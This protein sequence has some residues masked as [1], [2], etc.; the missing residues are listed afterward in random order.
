MPSPRASGSAAV[1]IGATEPSYDAAATDGYWSLPFKSSDLDRE[2][3]VATDPLLG[4]GRAAVGGY[5]QR[6]TVEGT[7]V[8]PIDVRAVGFWLHGLMGAP[9]T[10]GAASAGEITFSAQPVAE[11][12]ITLNG[13]AWTFKT[14]GAT[15][16]QTNIGVSLAATLT[17]LAADLNASAS[18]EIAKNT[19]TATATQLRIVS[20]TP[21][22][23]GNTYTLAASATSKGTVSAGT[24]KGGGFSHV[25]TAGADIPSKSLQVGH[26]GLTTPK[27][28]LYTGCFLGTFNTSVA[29]DAPANASVQ[30]IGR[31]KELRT[32]T[33]DATVVSHQVDRFS[34]SRAGITY[35]GSNGINFLT[36]AEFNY[37]NNLE[38]FNEIAPTDVIGG[39]D[40]G[41]AQPSGSLTVRL[42]DSAAQ[43]DL[44]SRIET[45]DPV[46]LT[47]TYGHG[48]RWS[49]VFDMPRVL[50]S[51]AKAPITGPG[52]IEQTFQWLAE[53]DSAEGYGLRATLI[54]DVAAYL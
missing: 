6:Q 26:S 53:H 17:A 31:R 48:N 28:S 14:S 21:G 16:T 15:G 3:A 13:V 2:R 5:Y 25:F 22:V 47:Y 36:G 43:A 27:Y 40:P 1:L 46:S 29:G 11:S 7:I 20:D 39:A 49:L 19:Y 18:A 54:N 52:G 23:S 24:L 34:S 38:V 50:L 35:N 10:T 45:E 4:Q 42:S 9:V 51:S 32:S 41:I 33:I 12:T 8:I 37:T 30:V 44:E